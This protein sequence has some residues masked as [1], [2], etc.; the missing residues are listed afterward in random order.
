MIRC[1]VAAAVEALVD[2]QARVKFFERKVNEEVTEFA[3][4]LVKRARTTWLERAFLDACSLSKTNLSAAQQ[5]IDNNMPLLSKANIK[6]SDIH[7]ILFRFV[8]GVSRGR[9][10]GD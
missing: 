9:P 7:P 8:Q 5:Q 3:R 4:D 2:Y 1:C 6:T 10:C